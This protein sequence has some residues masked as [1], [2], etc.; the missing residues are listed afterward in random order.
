MRTVFSRELVFCLSFQS[1]QLLVPDITTVLPVFRIAPEPLRK[2]FIH[3]LP[4]ELSEKD[5]GT[6]MTAQKVV[7]P[8][9][10]SQF[11]SQLRTQK[12]SSKVT[13]EFDNATSVDN[14]NKPFSDSQRISRHT[15]LPTHVGSRWSEIASNQ[16]ATWSSSSSDSAQPNSPSRIQVASP[17]CPRRR[18]S[19]EQL[20]VDELEGLL[21]EI[22]E[23]TESTSSDDGLFSSRSLSLQASTGINTSNIPDYKAALEAVK[24]R[25]AEEQTMR[26]CTSLPNLPTR[27]ES[28]VASNEVVQWDE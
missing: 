20:P 24:R 1:A 15:S 6:I 2:A 8:T 12:S 7:A 21:P 5:T 18:Q 25:Y 22:E 13:I 14:P 28:V 19:I 27:R 10:L 9:A 17:S 3:C 16:N 4:E 23:S 26:V 11:M